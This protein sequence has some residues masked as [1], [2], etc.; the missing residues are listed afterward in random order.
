V[1]VLANTASLPAKTDLGTYVER[2]GRICEMAGNC[3]LVEVANEISHRTQRADV[4]DPGVL[5]RWAARVPIGIPTA[6][7]APADENG[8]LVGV[9]PVITIHLDR[10]RDR[11]AR[12]SRVRKLE[13]TSAT[14]HRFVID[15]EPMGADEIEQPGQ[16]DNLPGVFF[17][18]GALSRVFEVGSNFHFEDGLGATVPRPVQQQCA[19]AFIAGTRI[20]DDSYML[21]FQ[22]AGW[23]YSPVQKAHFAGAVQAP[24]ASGRS[25]SRNAADSV[26]AAYAGLTQ[27]FPQSSAPSSVLVLIG[28]EGDPGVEWRRPWQKVGVIAA[29]PHVQV[30]SISRLP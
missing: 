13:A 19:E 14:T 25:D 21:T 10:S 15:N 9:A 6:L 12:V 23:P 11:W 17:V 18:Q 4:H 5:A 24:G 22:D 28:V 7:G 8:A 26:V 27:V 29:L 16:R 20:V 3:A 2:A 30:W 1:T